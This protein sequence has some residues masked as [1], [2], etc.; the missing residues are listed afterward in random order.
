MRSSIVERNA[1]SAATSRLSGLP[2]VLFVAGSLLLCAA[3]T[4]TA[5]AF[6]FEYQLG[7]HSFP[8]PNFALVSDS[9]YLTL[10]GFRVSNPLGRVPNLSFVAAY[11]Y[12]STSESHYS[13]SYYYDDEYA[14]SGDTS[15]YSYDAS[16]YATLRLHSLDVGVKW[17]YPIRRWLV[18]Y[19]TLTARGQV[20]FLNLSDDLTSWTLPD[21]SDPTGTENLYEVKPLRDVGFSGGLQASV[22]LVLMFKQPGA[23]L[24][25]KADSTS[26][27]PYRPSDARSPQDGAGPY[28]CSLG[29][30]QETGATEN[31]AEAET[32]DEGP[33]T[34][35][36]DAGAPNEEP[37]AL[38]E[39]PEALPEDS[40]EGMGHHDEAGA[41]PDDSSGSAENVEPVAPRD[42]IV[43][44]STDQKQTSGW[45]WGVSME[46]GSSLQTDLRFADAGS[47]D[48]GNFRFQFGLIITF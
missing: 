27:I 45:G 28:T 18:P 9:K 1:G 13:D 20:G 10:N 33:E 40:S 41:L 8:D 44:Q 4:Q 42:D 23:D 47:L 5:S 26:R 34:L 7:A 36:E 22:G 3:W 30:G 6:E 21:E 2:G 17:A 14:Y 16:V 12:G 29:Q 15:F 25:S 39:E 11:E 19:A 43:S 46:A 24:V 32:P 35:D 48:V 38:D 37:G 31:G